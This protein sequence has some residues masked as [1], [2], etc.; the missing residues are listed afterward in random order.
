M[1]AEAASKTKCRQVEGE[2]YLLSKSRPDLSNLAGQLRSQKVSRSAAAI[3]WSKITP[4]N[5]DHQG[6]SPSVLENVSPH[7]MSQ[8]YAQFDSQLLAPLFPTATHSSETPATSQVYGVTPSVN[9]K[10]RADLPILYFLEV[11]RPSL[12]IC[13]PSTCASFCSSSSARLLL[14]LSLKSASSTLKPS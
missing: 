11:L 13:L 5:I 12:S 14:M 8:A 2:L 1:V 3:F 10:R 7:V 4:E 6:I 9:I